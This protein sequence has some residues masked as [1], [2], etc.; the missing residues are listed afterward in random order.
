MVSIIYSQNWT[1]I[2]KPVS[3]SIQWPVERW[4]HAASHITGPMFMMSGGR[5][6]IGTT[7]SDI[8]LCDSTTNQWIKVFHNVQI[9]YS[10]GNFVNLK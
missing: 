1:K 6:G 10:H 8:R 9:N 5:G 3:Q 2:K 7:L 4:G